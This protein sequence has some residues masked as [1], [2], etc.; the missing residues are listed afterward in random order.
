MQIL[1]AKLNPVDQAISD[2]SLG[3][4]RRKVRDRSFTAGQ[5]GWKVLIRGRIGHRTV[6]VSLDRAAIIN[7]Y[8]K[9]PRETIK[10]AVS[11]GNC[12]RTAAIL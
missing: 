5:S 1:A 12:S 11:V 10:Q 2:I 9:W 6:T 3:A 7:Y 8:P 4:K